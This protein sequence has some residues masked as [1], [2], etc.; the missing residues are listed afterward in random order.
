M[1]IGELRGIK[2]AITGGTG[3]LGSP[4][5]RKL[6]SMGCFIRLLVPQQE[7]APKS[8]SGVQIV[9]GDINNEIAV[10]RLLEGMQLVFHLAAKVHDFSGRHYSEFERVNID[11]TRLLMTNAGIAGVRRVVFYSTVGVYGKDGNFNGDERSPCSPQNPYAASKYSAEKIVLSHPGVG[12]VEGVVLRFPVVYGQLDRGNMAKMID[13]IRRHRFA[14]LGSGLNIRSMI[15]ATNAAEAAVLAGFGQNCAGKI[16]CVTDGVDYTLNELVEIICKC[17]A[18]SWRPQRL[19]VWIAKVIGMA[20]DVLGMALGRPIPFGLATVR[21]LSTDLTFSC[22][23]IKNELG[24][25][26]VQSL[27]DGIMEEVK[28]I[29]YR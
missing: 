24:Y 29:V 21:K 27:E 16:Y 7:A 18:T 19:P 2:V 20:G 8:I 17:L 4:L 14:V 3:C 9:P 10:A 11:G 28:G 15:N 6:Q 13:A 5:L 12:G 22:E 1:H 26:P 23:R 25:T